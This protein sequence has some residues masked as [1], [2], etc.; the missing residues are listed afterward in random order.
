MEMR[1]IS[2]D[3]EFAQ[4]LH[5]YMQ[6]NDLTLD[7]FICTRETWRQWIDVDVHARNQYVEKGWGG[8]YPLYKGV[9]FLE[10]AS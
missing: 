10:S 5:D 2:R 9:F 8:V 3:K 4:Q 1:K 6:E 7:Q